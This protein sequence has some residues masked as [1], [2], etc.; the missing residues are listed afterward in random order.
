MKLFYALIN[1]PVKIV[2]MIID[3]KFRARGIVVP[4]WCDRI[5]KEKSLIEKPT[6]K[7]EGFDMDGQKVSV[8]KRL[9]I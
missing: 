6:P 1:T 7:V 3:Y 5:L 8:P 4:D 9:S 2:A